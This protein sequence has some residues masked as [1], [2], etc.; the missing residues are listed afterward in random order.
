[1][2]KHKWH[3]RQWQYK[4]IIISISIQHLVQK[5]YMDFFLLLNVCT[6]SDQSMEACSM[7]HGIWYERNGKISNKLKHWNVSGKKVQEMSWL[8][9]IRMVCCCNISFILPF[10]RSSIYK[11]YLHTIKIS[12][13]MIAPKQLTIS[14]WNPIKKNKIWNGKNKKSPKTKIW[15]VG[16]CD[17]V[18]LYLVELQEHY[19]SYL[20]GFLTI[21]LHIHH[22]LWQF[23]FRSHFPFL[24]FFVY[25][26]DI[27][28]IWLVFRSFPFPRFNNHNGFCWFP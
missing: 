27:Q 18:L 12:Y 4:W 23:I 5:R 21:F 1:M 14:D 25:A 7:E 6:Q 24:M 11:F 8:L 17:V 28:Y 20:Y 22:L 16:M 13:W 10:S 9:V 15:V 26:V 2:K 3:Y 19:N